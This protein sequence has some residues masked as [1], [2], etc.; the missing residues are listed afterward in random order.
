MIAGRSLLA[1]IAMILLSSAA[2]AQL[3]PERQTGT[4]LPALPKTVPS[5]ETGYIR[6]AFARCI[7]RRD[8]AA[9]DALLRSSD[10]GGIDFKAAGVPIEKLHERL[11]LSDCLGKQAGVDQAAIGLAMKPN[12]LRA[13][14]LEEAYLAKRSAAPATAS[15][16]PAARAFIAPPDKEGTMRAMADFADCLAE[17]DTPGADRLLRTMPGSKDVEAAARGLTPTLSSCLSEGQTLTFAP[18]SI[19]AYAADGLW[20][21]YVAGTPAAEAGR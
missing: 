11:G 6:K 21:R 8:P 5:D 20:N 19:R 17:L 18:H 1:A 2:S 7:Y 9:A 10:P 15:M 14:L 4:R 16:V 12:L 13:L 3:Q